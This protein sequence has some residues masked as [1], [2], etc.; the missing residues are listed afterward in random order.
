MHQNRGCLHSPLF[1]LRMRPSACSCRRHA[2]AQWC[3]MGFTADTGPLLP[4]PFP[5]AVSAHCFTIKNAT[6]RP[7]CAGM[8]SSKGAALLL[9]APLWLACTLAVDTAPTL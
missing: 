2:A 8:L 5:P 6:L 9:R 1:Y 3:E 4:H 7:W